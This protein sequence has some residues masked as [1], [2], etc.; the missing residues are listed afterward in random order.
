MKDP[1]S[2]ICDVAHGKRP[3]LSK[4]IKTFQYLWLEKDAQTINKSNMLSEL[5]YPI[6]IRKMLRQE[7]S[8]YFEKMKPNIL[9][10][11]FF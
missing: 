2:D 6:N 8:K 4:L 11:I 10:I 7:E 1:H 5:I 3:H 9:G